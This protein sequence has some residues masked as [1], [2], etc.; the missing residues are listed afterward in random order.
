M[1]W[2]LRTAK[3]HRHQRPLFEQLPSIDARVWS[4][5]RLFPP[6]FVDRYVYDWPSTAIQSAVL[7]RSAVEITHRS[8]REQTIPVWWQRT[9]FGQRPGFLC[10]R[11]SRRAFRL[12]AHHQQ[13]ACYKC[14]DAIY[15]SQSVSSRTR[16]AVQAARLRHYLGDWEEKK[17][18]PK[19]PS[20][21][22]L[23]TFHRLTGRLTAWEAKS[24]EHWCSRRVKD[25]GSLLMPRIAYSTQ[26]AA[27][28]R[29]GA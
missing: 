18:K 10:P 9:G 4:R 6:N 13:F 17:E 3:R 15:L 14:C 21:M 1:P 8:G 16:A 20:R 5:R 28:D 26:S 7:T 24:P 23:S 25:D 22:P 29:I 19:R 2:Q 27:N 11:C 12:Y